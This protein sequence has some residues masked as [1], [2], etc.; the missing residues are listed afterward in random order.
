[1]KHM[2]NIKTGRVAVYDAEL[3]QS[4]R[5]EEVG[6][7][8]KVEA[9]KPGAN[10]VVAVQDEVKITVTRGKDESKQRKA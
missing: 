3:V 2:R 9:K 1:M 4:G 6:A 10:D 5:W 7:E 8:P